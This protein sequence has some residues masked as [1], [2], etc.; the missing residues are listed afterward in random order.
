MWWV[1]ICAV[2]NRVTVI[3]LNKRPLRLQ[4]IIS[5]SLRVLCLVNEQR[6]YG[7]S[8][9]RALDDRVSIQ[10]LFCCHESSVTTSWQLRRCSLYQRRKSIQTSLLCGTALDKQYLTWSVAFMGDFCV[11]IRHGP[12]LKNKSCVHIITCMCRMCRVYLSIYLSM[13]VSLSIHGIFLNQLQCSWEQHFELETDITYVSI[14]ATCLAICF[15]SL[16][17]GMH[18]GLVSPGKSKY[19]SLTLKMSCRC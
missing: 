11:L 15:I 1:G 8:P 6:W 14:Y 10:I 5:I 19:K 18:L 17:K 9:C 7:V 12:L 13:S 4:V 2:R 16:V 3:C